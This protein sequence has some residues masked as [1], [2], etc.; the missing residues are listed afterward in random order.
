MAN[1]Y[2]FD[3]NKQFQNVSGVNNV[4][5]FLRVFYNGT[6]DRP[7]TYKDF[8]G[9]ANPAD[10]PV[11]N[12]GRAVVIVNDSYTYRLEVYGRD[13]ALLWSQY[14][15]T[16]IGSGGGGGAGNAVLTVRKDMNH[17]GTYDTLG[18]FTANGPDSTVTIP[19]DAYV[20]SIG[21][22][23]SYFNDIVYAYIDGKP[24]FARESYSWYDGDVQKQDDYTYTAVDMYSE[25]G[26]IY[27]GTAYIIF[28]RIDSKTD[29]IVV[30][31][32]KNGTPGSVAAYAIWERTEIP[33]HPANSDVFYAEYNVTDFDDIKTAY[34][35]GKCVMLKNTIA[36]GD[37]I[38][39][40]CEYNH[41][42]AMPQFDTFVFE[43][44]VAGT[45]IHKITRFRD[46]WNYQSYT[47]VT[48]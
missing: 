16:P 48:Q 29:K 22:Q 35:A 36:E 18:T 11:D 2:L 21:T 32:C 28:V 12:N 42:D 4:A 6:D 30:Q 10:I 39:H 47:L 1:Q 13:G 37:E 33:L 43:C 31:K 44:I 15:L 38:Y 14:P 45:I 5:G 40:L 23:L 19:K 8:N 34:D 17:Y 7:V 20:F 24:V 9:T 27:D 46:Q 3:P 41:S 25:G 26:S